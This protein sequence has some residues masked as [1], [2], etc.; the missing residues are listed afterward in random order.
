MNKY[1]D[2]AGGVIDI[3][4][5]SIELVQTYAVQGDQVWMGGYSIRRDRE[6]KEI[7]RTPNTWN[8]RMSNV[9]DYCLPLIRGE[10]LEPT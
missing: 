10:R 2:A 1:A 9:P 5:G 4:Y 7:S 3:L 6:G 8:V